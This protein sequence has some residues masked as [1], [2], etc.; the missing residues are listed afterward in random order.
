MFGLISTM[1]EIAGAVLI[2]V[3]TGICFGLGAGLIVAGA[4]AITGSLLA[5]RAAGVTE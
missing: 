1:I 4:L 3:G 2:A 5:T